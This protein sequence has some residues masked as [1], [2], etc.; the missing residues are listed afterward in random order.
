MALEQKQ[1]HS[2]G[3]MDIVTIINI[4]DGYFWS[5]SSHSEAPRLS[6]VSCK[7]ILEK[8]S[9]AAQNSLCSNFDVFRRK[10]IT[11]RFYVIINLIS[12]GVV[13]SYLNIIFVLF[14]FVSCTSRSF[15]LVIFV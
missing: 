14:V 2:I 7:S 10:T 8:R 6:F 12:K 1:N 9:V 11:A 3:K 4:I 15:F 5:L 13:T